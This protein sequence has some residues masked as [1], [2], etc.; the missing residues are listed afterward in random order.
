MEKHKLELH[1]QALRE[2]QQT[3]SFRARGWAMFPFAIKLGVLMY[4]GG[5]SQS[6]FQ[7]ISRWLGS[8]SQTSAYVMS[9]AWRE[10]TKA[11]AWAYFSACNFQPR[12][13]KFGL[14]RTAV[15][16]IDNFNPKRFVG[17]GMDFYCPASQQGQLASVPYIPRK[18]G[19][20]VM[21]SQFDGT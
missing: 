2:V 19:V 3:A 7:F 13:V 11:A 14:L 21:Q 6:M 4:L 1:K 8:I 15:F 17:D 5:L 20:K 18:A 9:C 10:T 16:L 12:A